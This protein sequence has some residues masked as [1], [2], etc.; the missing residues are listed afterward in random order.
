MV[1]FTCESTVTPSVSAP[2]Y[3]CFAVPMK[4]RSGTSLID[5][6]V[7]TVQTPTFGTTTRFP[8]VAGPVT[9]QNL[10]G[11]QAAPCVAT[12]FRRGLTTTGF[13]GLPVPLSGM[14]FDAL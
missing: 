4:P 2:R 8:Q 14:A 9:R 6:S 5:P 12:S 11:S 13:P 7:P 3:D 10:P 1:T